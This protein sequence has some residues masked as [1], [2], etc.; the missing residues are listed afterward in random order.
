[1]PASNISLIIA[2]NL[3]GKEIFRMAAMLF[4]I[5]NNV[6]LKETAHWST[7]YYRTSLQDLVALVAPKP[8]DFA[9]PPCLC[10]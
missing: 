9:R 2:T 6:T 8:Q 4:Y 1:M 3:K 10:N 7:T 5:L